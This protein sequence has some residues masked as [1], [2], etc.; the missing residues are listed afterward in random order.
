MSRP[1]V[2][3]ATWLRP[4]LALFGRRWSSFHICGVTGLFL[5][6]C[7]AM[8]LAGQ[9]GLSRA[10]VAALLA[11]G[12]V[13][14]L[15]L[16]MATKIITGRES[17]VY[18][19]HEVAILSVSAALLAAFNQPVLP[20][21]DVTALGLGVFLAFGRCGC[22]LVGCC[23]G[24]PHRWGVRYGDQH[25]T[26]GFPECYVGVRL[27]PVQALESITV[28][29]IV[30]AG[31]ALVLRGSPAGA[32]LS[33]YIV[34]YST[35]RI[36]LEELRGDRARPYWLQLSEA[37]WTSLLLIVS[38][39]VGEWQGR[40]PFSTWHLVMCGG[41]AISLVVLASGRTVADAIVHPRHAS[42]IAAIIKSLPQTTQGAVA[43]QRTSLTV[44]VSTASLERGDAVLYALS[45]VDRRLT[46]SEARALA[47][48]IGNLVSRSG[49]RHELL[50]GNY[51]VFHVIL[52]QSPG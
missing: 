3:P 12:V 5:G 14:F 26:E 16:T 48:L 9:A 25:A 7:L 27:F 40:L 50:R 24:K 18:Y 2:T 17:L 35:A 29:L 20:Y 49:G 13:T 11:M 37:Q 1:D 36:W 32:A 4:R 19:H 28:A 47:R 21:L 10:V 43:V 15:A 6:T 42:E 52:H 39:V 46:L 31:S 22:L 33:W 30:A 41:A 38:V 51:G 8:V 44:G 45:R 23:H 34:S